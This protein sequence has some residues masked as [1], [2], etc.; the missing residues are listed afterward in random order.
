MIDAKAYFL[1]LLFEHMRARFFLNTP[2]LPPVFPS[3]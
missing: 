3:L 1:S 2:D